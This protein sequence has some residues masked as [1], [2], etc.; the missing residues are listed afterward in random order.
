[1]NNRIYKIYGLFD[2]R[3]SKLRYIGFT[4]QELKGRLRQHL[5][6][7]R[8]FTEH[9]HKNCWIKKLISI[10]LLP[11]IKLLRIT[12]IGSWIDDEKELILLAK[13]LG[14][15]LTNEASG[16]QRSLV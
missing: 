1:M 12:T 15:S 8:L 2:P 9:T 6:K 13:H 16:G 3:D 5:R 4:S 10:G 7:K 11:E 14:F